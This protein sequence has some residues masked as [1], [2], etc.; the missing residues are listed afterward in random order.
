MKLKNQ[1]RFYLTSKEVEMI[2]KADLAAFPEFA[3]CRE[4]LMAQCKTGTCFDDIKKQAPFKSNKYFQNVDCYCI[5][6]EELLAAL[7]IDKR[8]ASASLGQRTYAMNRLENR[9]RTGVSEA[10]KDV[11]VKNATSKK[12]NHSLDKFNE[13]P[14]GRRYLTAE[15]VAA[16]QNIDLE[17]GDP[18]K[19]IR[20]SFLLQCYTGA[21]LSDCVKDEDLE[22]YNTG[23][24]ELLQIVGIAKPVVTFCNA[25][26]DTWGWFYPDPRLARH[27]YAIN[28]HLY[29]SVLS[30]DVTL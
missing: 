17:D 9:V 10:R 22:F 30:N 20:D 2:N 13:L 18:L 19:G 4:F 11:I 12:S 26:G 3:N 1:T 15:E 21:R 7:G 5:L 14:S 28:T 16:I 24:G 25:K 23:V 8:L 29:G 6:L 27:T